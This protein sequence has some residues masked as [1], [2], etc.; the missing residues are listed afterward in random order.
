MSSISLHH[1][2]KCLVLVTL[3]SA[4]PGI[5]AAQ[6]AGASTKVEEITVTARKR[7]EDLQSVPI[8]ISAFS[9]ADLQVRDIVNLEKL[10]D[11]T[12][13]LSFGTAGSIV[14]R[15]PIIR[16]VAQQTRVGDEPNVATFI[17]GVNAAVQSAS[18][19]PPSSLC[20]AN[21]CGTAALQGSYKHT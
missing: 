14:N 13:G 15:R 1:G 6:T 17:D 3:A 12:P 9:A 18:C 2:V 8:S 4:F 5:T 19:W 21:P 11:Q 7:E 16:G 20:G 10:A